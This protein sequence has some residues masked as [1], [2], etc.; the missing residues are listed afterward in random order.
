MV[1]LYRPGPLEMIPEY[2]KHKHKNPDPF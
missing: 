2:I 1:A